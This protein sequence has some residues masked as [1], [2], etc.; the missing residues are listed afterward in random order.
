MTCLDCHDLH[1]ASGSADMSLKVTQTDTFDS[2]V[3]EGHSAPVLCVGLDR[4]SPP[5]YLASSGCDGKVKVWSLDDQKC[6]FTWTNCHTA[7]NDVESSVT[8]AG[9][10]FSPAAGEK[11]AV[12]RKNS[13]KVTRHIGSS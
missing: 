3:L 4:K 13:V 6:V 11:L 12:A 9:V 2:V 8:M 10:A 5:E 7:C 1:V